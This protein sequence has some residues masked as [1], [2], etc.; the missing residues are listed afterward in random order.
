MTCFAGKPVVLE[1]LYIVLWREL[2]T[3]L[4]T[5]PAAFPLQD[6]IPY[7]KQNSTGASWRQRTQDDQVAE[8]WSKVQIIGAKCDGTQDRGA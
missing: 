3:R 6:N 7:P 5:L 2:P 8:V 4:K 1:F